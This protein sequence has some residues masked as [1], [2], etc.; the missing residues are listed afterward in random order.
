MDELRA[1]VSENLSSL[2]KAKHLTQ[3]ELADRIGYSDKSVS[4]WELGKAIPTVDILKQFADF[5]GVTVDFLI[6]AQSAQQRDKALKGD[7]KTN[8]NRIIII[9]MVAT[10][11]W[12]TAACVYASSILNGLGN[13]WSAFVWA[14]PASI[15]TTGFLI[16]WFWGKT[17]NFYICSSLFIWAFLTAVCIQLAFYPPHQQLWYIYFVGIPLQIG[18]ILLRGWKK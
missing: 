2:R 1:I 14:I 6:T 4:K 11:V 15:L 18:I 17:I 8:N 5:Y 3:Q 16:F 13:W 10:F 9:A 12:F 7:Q